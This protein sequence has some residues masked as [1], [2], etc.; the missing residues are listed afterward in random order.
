MRKKKRLPY[1]SKLTPYIT[2][3]PCAVIQ[4]YV[5]MPELSNCFGKS[6]AKRIWNGEVEINKE[7]ASELDRL[8]DLSAKRW[9][10]LQGKWELWKV[11][12]TAVSCID[13]HHGESSVRLFF[14][15]LHQFRNSKP[16]IEAASIA[17]ELAEVAY[18][19]EREYQRLR[20]KVATHD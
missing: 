11:V 7:I 12:H 6:M 14:H 10:Q 19:D 17:Q 20:R 16:L 3:K 18:T 2:D 9:L 8:T 15:Y 13:L 4:E 5:C 1:S